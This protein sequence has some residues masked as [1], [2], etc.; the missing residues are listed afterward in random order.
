MPRLL[1]IAPVNRYTDWRIP[2]NGD[3]MVLRVISC[4]VVL[5]ACARAPAYTLGVRDGYELGEDPTIAVAIREPSSG[6]ALL[7]ITKPDGSTVR[8]KVGLGVAQ[9]NI[10]F[11]TPVE[12]GRE[13]TFS[14]TG[15]YRVELRLNE[16]ILA[17]QE[18]R[19]STDRLTEMFGDGEVA[20]FEPVARYTRAKQH[21]QRHWK[22]YG[23]LYEH[24]LRSDVQIQVVIEEP[25]DALADAWKPYEEE[26]MLGV[27]ENNH[28]RFRE[29]T[30]SV[31][32]SWIA[33]KRIIAMRA[34]TLDDFQRGFI[35][36]FLARYPSDLRA[37]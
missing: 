24:T 2:Y 32:A 30:G 20:S 5:A 6:D 33:G 14:A 9:T 19:I 13:P 27:I 34:A 25:G 26:G 18:I 7:V 12:R 15:D 36:Y 3:R 11:N 31:S 10:R 37:L 4:L 1:L 35:A 23:A 29:R 21:K 8:Q 28:V 22:T 16:A 17:K